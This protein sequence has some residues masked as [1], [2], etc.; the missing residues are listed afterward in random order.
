MSGCGITFRR[1]IIDVLLVV[2]R[3]L[4]AACESGGYTPRSPDRHTG[5]VSG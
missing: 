1:T 3:D 2:T 5:D 4:I